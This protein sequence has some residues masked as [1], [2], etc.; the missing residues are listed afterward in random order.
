MALLVVRMRGTVNVPYWALTTLKNLYLNKKFSATLVP[1]TTN[2]LGMLRK[3]N[4][5][6]AWSKADSDIIK[7]LIEKRGK[8]KSPTL[9]SKDENKSKS[10]YKG[11]DELV[12]VIVNDKIKFSDQNN[13]KPWFSL[14]PP[15]GGFKKNTK[16]QFSDGGI[17]G[18][19]K[20][21][22][23]IVKRMV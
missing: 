12:D 4:Q 7:T 16:R 13:I 5:W 11:I 21:L 9:E 8:K 14:N 10:D 15:K 22:L 3:I 18:N 19:N 2:Y 20:E 6:V 17:L 1:E 23:E